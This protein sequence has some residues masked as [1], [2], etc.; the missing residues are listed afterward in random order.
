MKPRSAET[1][2]LLRHLIPMAFTCQDFIAVLDHYLADSLDGE[3]QALAEAHLSGCSD[4]TAYLHSYEETIRL[5][6]AAFSPEDDAPED[7][8]SG[9]LAALQRSW[10]ALLH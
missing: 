2:L 7:F 9:A 10:R 1:F 8:V 5:S 3:R 4:C 6:K